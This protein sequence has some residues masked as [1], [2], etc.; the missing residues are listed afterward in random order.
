METAV[1]IGLWIATSV[2]VGVPLGYV[3]YRLGQGDRT[4]APTV[5]HDAEVAARIVGL[6]LVGPADPFSF[7]DQ[8]R[9]RVAEVRR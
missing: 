6:D 7:E 3:C 1:L 5:E 8:L 9:R 2:V 4:P